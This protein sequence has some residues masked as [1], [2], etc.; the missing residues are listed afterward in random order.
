M[1]ILWPYENGE[2]GE[3]FYA[4]Y[5]HPA[6]AEGE[7]EL[8]RLGGGTAVLFPSGTGAATALALS[9]VRPGDTIA[10]AEGAYFGTGRLFE[11]LA[12]WGLRQVEFD[13]TGPP[14]ADAQL[15]WV[16]AP[17]N[18]MLTLPGLYDHAGHPA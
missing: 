18:A 6:V 15:L 11:A 3:F 7:A 8:G 1:E 2:V 13:Q 17:A 14:P 5:N 16:E 12:P 10:L 9:L 4:R